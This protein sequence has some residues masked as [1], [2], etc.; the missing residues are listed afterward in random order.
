MTLLIG[1]DAGA[2]HS[3]AFV[4]GPSLDVVARASGAAGAVA[5][6]TVAEA[7]AAIVA[8]MRTALAAARADRAGALVVGAAGAGRE[9]ERTELERALA[10]AGVADRVRVTTDIEIALVAALGDGPGILLLAGTGSG[11]CARLPGGEIRRTG[12]HGWQFGDEG[13][14][15][16]LAR[17]ALAAM[18]RASD[19]RGPATAF[20]AA[21]ATAA[22]VDANAQAVLAWART[23]PRAAVADLARVVQEAAAGGDAVARELVEQTATDLVAHVRALVP[24]FAGPAAVPVAIAG[25][26][27]R[28]RQPVRRAVL[29]LLADAGPRVCVNEAVV[30]PPRGALLLASRLA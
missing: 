20:T 5:P 21:A 22:G 11:A 28:G 1:V 25:G 24:L 12:G 13:S 8:T 2:S 4:S 27:V 19:G 16:A 6:G 14:G 30:E 3:T 7:S 29:R 10:Q 9:P 15:Y 26:L 23:A 17:S 18:A